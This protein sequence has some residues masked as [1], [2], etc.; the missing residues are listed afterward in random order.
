MGRSLKHEDRKQIEAKMTSVFSESIQSL[1]KELQ[2]ILVDDIVT[3]FENRFQVL[4]RV[5]NS[6]ICQI[7]IVQD[8][9]YQRV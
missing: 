1:P 7:Q 9:D 6:R 8:E 3:A 4:N 5:Q 2:R